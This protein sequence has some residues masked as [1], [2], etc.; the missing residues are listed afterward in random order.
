MNT[1]T[2]K[3]TKTV[4]KTIPQSNTNKTITKHE[5]IRLKNIGYLIFLLGI[6][7]MSM[8]Y[9]Y[10]M[11]TQVNNTKKEIQITE[12]QLEEEKSKTL[13]RLNDD[14]VKSKVQNSDKKF[15]EENL[16][17]INKK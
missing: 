3:M 6:I 1:Q 12:K 11:E 9:T 4:N 7:A 17:N 16:I 2:Q 14:N 10:Q 5:K 15:R 13:I 8:V